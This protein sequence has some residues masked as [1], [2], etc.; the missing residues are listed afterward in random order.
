M[1]HKKHKHQQMPVYEG[2]SIT[3]DAIAQVLQHDIKR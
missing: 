3:Q 2:A 1:S